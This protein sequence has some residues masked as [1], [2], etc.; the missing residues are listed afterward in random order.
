M[1]RVSATQAPVSRDPLLRGAYDEDMWR[2]EYEQ[3]CATLKAKQKELLKAGGGVGEEFT[4]GVRSA[5]HGEMPRNYA[6]EG[7]EVGSKAN[8][9]DGGSFTV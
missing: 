9:G 1:Q 3:R 5:A 7:E 8:G 2:S 4:A 6:W